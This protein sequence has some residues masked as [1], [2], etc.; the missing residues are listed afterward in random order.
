MKKYFNIEGACNQNEHYMVNLEQRI[1]E[2]KKLV[3]QRKYF[4]IN[5]G[6]QYGKTTTLDCLQEKLCGQYSVFY[7]SFEGLAEESYRSEHAFCQVFAGLLYDTINYGETKGIADSARHA[8]KAMSGADGGNADFR[9]LSNLLSMICETS[10]M[11][12]VLMIDEVDQAG[13]QPVFL[14]FLGMLR[15]KYLKRRVR[16]AFQS[17]ILAGVYDVRNLKLKI[18]PETEH[19]KNSPWNI[20]AKFTVDMSFSRQEIER[21]LEEYEQDCRT[22]MDTAE[23]AGMIYDYTSGYPFLVSAICKIMDEELAEKGQNGELFPVWTKEG[24]L[25][26]VKELLSEKNPLFDSLVNKLEDYPRLR[27]MLHSMLFHGNKVL[28]NP[29]NHVIDVAAM[30]GFVKNDQGVMAVANRIFETRL[31]NLF[32]SEAETRNQMFAAGAMDQNQFVKNGFLDMDLVL[33]KFMVHWG[34]LYSSADEKF[35]EDYGRKF[36]LLYLMPIIS[37]TGNYYIES[38][39]RDNRRTDVIVDYRGKQY[40]IEIKLW[41]GEEYNRRGE[42]QLADYLEAYHVKKGYLLSFNFNKNKVAGIKERKCGDKV[43]LEVVV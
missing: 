2:I 26:A 11:P 20:A 15:N 1:Q 31:Y 19:Q 4:S 43:I 35:V 21:M 8:L 37:G 14:S 32:L 10:D 33:E 16:P 41:R 36:F 23:L 28:F 38:R 40:I 29:D 34:D 5:R 42:A 25:E 13:G 39:T 3:G 17:V 12:V 27:E 24:V 18:R 30:F 6:R 22:G 9:R 7:I